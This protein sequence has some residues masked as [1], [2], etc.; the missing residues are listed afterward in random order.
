MKY[1]QPI[2]LFSTS[3]VEFSGIRFVKI[4]KDLEL[5]HFNVKNG[6][7]NISLYIISEGN[8]DI[9]C[10]QKLDVK[11]KKIQLFFKLFYPE[12]QLRKDVPPLFIDKN[13]SSGLNR[14]DPDPIMTS[15]LEKYMS[16]E[17]VIQESQLGIA[18]DS[19]EKG[20]IFVGFPKLVNWLD[21]NKHKGYS[22]FCSIRNVLFHGETDDAILKVQQ[23]FPG[24]F[25][26]DGKAFDQTNMDNR[27]KIQEYLPEL[28]KQ[29]KRVFKEKYATNVWMEND[30]CEKCDG[31]L[32]LD[33]II[34]KSEDTKNHLTVKKF[35]CDKNPEH[36]FIHN[37]LSFSE[38]ISSSHD[39]A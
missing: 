8:T 38:V 1:I 20:D 23:E 4:C 26:F 39:P 18:L 29:V 14:F 19:I 3:N 22:K 7:R 11:F 13:S 12:V 24:E 32:K 9:D 21:E 17:F 2:I 15:F 30:P 33:P 6:I 36:F 25:V 5:N 10:A 16:R 28:L 34:K 31:V 27:N 37:I 35:I